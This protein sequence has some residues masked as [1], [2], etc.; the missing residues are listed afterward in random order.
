MHNWFLKSL[1]KPNS[2]NRNVWDYWWSFIYILNF[3]HVLMPYVYFLQLIFLKEYTV[4]EGQTFHFKHFCCF[5]CDIPLAE[6]SYVSKDDNPVCLPCYERKYSK[7]SY[8]TFLNIHSSI[9]FFNVIL[10]SIRDATVAVIRSKQVTRELVGKSWAG[11][12]QHRVL[13]AF[14]AW[15]RYLEANLLSEM[16]NRYVVRNALFS[17]ILRLAEGIW[18]L[19][20]IS[21]D[22]TEFSENLMIRVT[23]F[24]QKFV[25]FSEL[26]WCLQVN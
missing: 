24:E 10:S 14:N 26:L 19:S 16:T 7:V 20:T 22:V 12:R 23:S 15:N 13:N 1:L 11:M 18:L 17:L 21:N 8:L 2:E 25:L 5:E 3:L 9:S 6:K 4:A